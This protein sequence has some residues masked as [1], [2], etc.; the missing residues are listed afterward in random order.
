V[1]TGGIG[2]YA[3]I[4]MLIAF[5][6]LHNSRRKG[7]IQKPGHKA[8]PAASQLEPSLGVLLIDFFRLYGRV[9]NVKDVSYIATN[10]DFLALLFLKPCRGLFFM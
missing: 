4:T 7:P 10:V 9:I 3:L 1:Y 6:Q 5:L 2:S 8:R